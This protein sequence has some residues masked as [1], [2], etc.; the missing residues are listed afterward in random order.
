MPLQKKIIITQHS[1]FGQSSEQHTH[2]TTWQ[3]PKKKNIQAHM[4]LASD[5]FF[6][7]WPCD[8]ASTGIGRD[9]RCDSQHHQS[10]GRKN[11]RP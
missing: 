2:K 8:Q 1:S 11:P 9:S 3:G 10:W 4:Q 5:S 6:I 7:L